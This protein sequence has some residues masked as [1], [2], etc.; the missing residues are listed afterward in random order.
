[1]K[2]Q[3]SI[4]GLGIYFLVA[5]LIRLPFFFRDCIDRDESTFILLGQ[6]WVDGFL[7]YTQLWDLKPPLVFLFFGIIIQIFGKSYIAIR[8]FG[9]IA[10]AFTAYFIQLIA[11]KGSHKEHGFYAG[12]LY[13]FLSSLFGSLQGVMSEHLALFF[14]M[15]GFLCFLNSTKNSQ[16]FLSGF[17]F[18]A[19]LMFRLNLIYPVGLLFLFYLFSSGFDLKEII[20]K[21][22]ISILGGIMVP[23]LTFLPY[24]NQEIPSVWWNAVIRA[25]FSYDNPSYFQMFE[26][27]LELTPFLALFFLSIIFRTRF[28]IYQENPRILVL[29]W[30]ITAGLFLMLIKSGKV[31]GHYLIQI[32]PFIILLFLHLL[33]SLKLSFFAK[34]KPALF[35]LFLLLPIE[36]YLEYVK[37]GK[38][39]LNGESLYNGNGLDISN[40][41][42]QNY[43][44]D[45]T[46]LFLDHHIGYWELNKL[47][48]S[49]IVTHP[50]N[51]MRVSNY[52]FVED[53]R[54]D[55]ISE[56]KYLLKVY[57]PELI[58]S[59][60]E[61]ISFSE[62]DSEENQ[63]YQQYLGE[64]YQLV[65]QKKRGLVYERVQKK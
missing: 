7:P 30:V 20:Q 57:Q 51:L 63:F 34:I 64:N 55:P 23:L 4:I 58:I 35:I 46:A 12:L 5:L 28:R 8:L 14:F 16:L 36:S 52:P 33:Y 38:R 27:V 47:P 18:G 65:Y 13:V 53:I 54:Q 15:L 40:F 25:S 29:I 26:A 56:L 1:M 43:P 48:P 3:S 22:L 17:L 59:R 62:K 49:K 31:N 2:S 21:G 60:S 6:S 41:I 42:Q 24:V 44:E 37:I 45:V 11:Q 10:I 32:Y 50:S 61:H 39:Y 9:T 19:A